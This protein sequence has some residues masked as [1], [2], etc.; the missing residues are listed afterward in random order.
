MSQDLLCEDCPP[1]G[2]PTNKTRCDPCPRHDPILS[3]INQ[4][5]EKVASWMMI[6]GYVTGHGDTIEDLLAELETQ[7]QPRR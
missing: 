3:V 7:I 2:Y 4:E 5:R 6:N 1:V